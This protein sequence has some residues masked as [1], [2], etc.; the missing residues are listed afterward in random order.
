[1]SDLPALTF[2]QFLKARREQ[3]GYKIE[4]ISKKSGLAW[5]SISYY[6]QDKSRP[7]STNLYKVAAVYG[8]TA[9]DLEPYELKHKKAEKIKPVAKV[10]Y[11]I[12]YGRKQ[13][14]AMMT[15]DS[16]FEQKMRAK[17]FSALNQ[18]EEILNEVKFLDD[19][20]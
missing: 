4:E 20:F 5:A 3:L 16:Q 19:A 15:G 6:E 13:I 2:G 12:G 8:L 9:N 17:L 7:H 11:A 18:C 10:Q 14:D 1:M